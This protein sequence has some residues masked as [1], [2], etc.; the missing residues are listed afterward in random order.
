VIYPP[1][2]FTDTTS[3]EHLHDHELFRYQMVNWRTVP[4]VITVSGEVVDVPE[5]SNDDF[6]NALQMC[7]VNGPLQN[8]PMTPRE[9]LEELIPERIK[10][11]LTDGEMTKE[12]QFQIESARMF[13]RM[14]MEEKYGEDYED[15]LLNEDHL[16]VPDPE[17]PDD[18]NGWRVPVW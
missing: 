15:D 12:K 4:A 3:P 5:K 8:T 7:A 10:S 11:L 17:D 14:Q 1:P 16:E 2:R 18:P 9:E 13:A 6:G